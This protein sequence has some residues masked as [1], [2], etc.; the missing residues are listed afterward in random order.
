MSL[1]DKTVKYSLEIHAPMHA[2]CCYLLVI[3]HSFKD[4]TTSTV[5]PLSNIVKLKVKF[6]NKYFVKSGSTKQYFNWHDQ[7]M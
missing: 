4:L 6:R 1:A 3:Q 5:L 2:M 7:K